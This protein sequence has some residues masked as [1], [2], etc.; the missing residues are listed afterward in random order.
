MRRNLVYFSDMSRYPILRFLTVSAALL[1][2]PIALAQD[3]GAGGGGQAIR[4]LE[5]IGG[6]NEI[7]VNGFEG[8]GVMNFYLGLLYPW[9]I[10]MGAGMA[11]LMATWGGLQIIM[12]GKDPSKAI[13]GKDRLIMSIA[14]LILI[15]ASATI[16]HALNPTFFK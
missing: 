8:L 9:L 10:G 14:G 7:P 2:V 4:L 5:P 13:A 16:M 3:P 1:T 12:A 6:V 15:L 11:V